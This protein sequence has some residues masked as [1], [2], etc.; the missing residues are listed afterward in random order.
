[1]KSDVESSSDL[2]AERFRG[3]V[4]EWFLEKQLFI[5]ES[6]LGSKNETILDVG[7]GHAQLANP[8]AAKGY[9]VTVAGSEPI[10]SKRLNHDVKFVAH[11]LY[12]LPFPDKSFD[13]VLCFRLISHSPE[14]KQLISELCR[15]SKKRVI[16]DYPNKMS[17]NLFT[18]MF[19]RIKR[20]LEG[21][22]RPYRMFL[23]NEVNQ[24][25]KDN[26]FRP[27][28]SEGQYFLPMILYKTIQSRSFGEQIEGFF[29]RLRL[30]AYSS[31]V[32]AAWIDEFEKLST[33]L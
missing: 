26:K 6:M 31:P 17:L 22:T 23:K 13:T 14:W 5:V 16:L 25:F 12:N 4:G 9:D 11:D 10:C 2:Y 18:P 33:R 7:G 21:T 29:N 3:P 20:R 27:E 32:I 24:A 30:Q 1:M 19:F 15:V 28:K 8:L